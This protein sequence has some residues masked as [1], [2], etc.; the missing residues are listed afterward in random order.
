MDGCG[1]TGN[2]LFTR[3]EQ[4]ILFLHAVLFC[5]ALHPF[6]NHAVPALHDYAHHLARA[7]VIRHPEEFKGVYAV[8]W[9]VAPYILSDL[10]LQFFAS[11]LDI[12]TAGRAYFVTAH[13]LII[14]AVI[15]ISRHLHGRISAA[16]LLAY[17]FFFSL[18][19][20]LGFINFIFGMGVALCSLYAWLRLKEILKGRW[21]FALL[22]MLFTFNFL[23]HALS[24]ACLAL[25][26]GLLECLPVIRNPKRLAGTGLYVGCAALPSFFALAAAPRESLKYTFTVTGIDHQAM[27]ALSPVFF[28]AAGLEI[29]I[30]G[31]FFLMFSCRFL[32]VDRSFAL[33][34]ALLAV[35]SFF[36]PAAFLGVSFTNIR[37]PVFLSLLACSVASF[38]WTDKMTAVVFVSFLSLCVSMNYFT[39]ATQTLG[40]CGKKIDEFVT[41]IRSLDLPPHQT[42]RVSDDA[43]ACSKNLG[44]D[45]I[46]LLTVIEKKLFVPYL[47]TLIPPVTVSEK[48]SRIAP[49]DGKSG[50]E[51][52][53]YILSLKENN[54]NRTEKGNLR[55][56]AA[57]S[58]FTLYEN[59]SWRPPE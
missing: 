16:T 5:V 8:H 11:F 55:Q 33:V 18:P 1:D 26:I 51:P 36:I 23:V 42:L 28:N 27:T 22:V 31:L 2:P 30:L 46:S 59:K 25:T 14:S 9:R 48:F 39:S 13:L 7:Y 37:L 54:T 43:G 53:R 12:Y 17:I 3:R 52:F 44:F 24:F 34:L 47:F 10:T 32:K 29:I 40:A 20:V 21:R 38:H 56:I 35:F 41:G 57:G 49:G 19:A 50:S 58:F 45:Y 15:A 4:V 6:L